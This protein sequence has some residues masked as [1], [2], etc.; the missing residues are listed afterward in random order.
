NPVHGGGADL[1]AV[2]LLVRARERIETELAGRNS[3]Q[4][5]LLCTVGASLSNLSAFAASRAA[6]EAAFKIGPPDGSGGAPVPES[7]QLDLAILLLG[8]DEIP[9]AE[10]ML[11]Q[12]EPALR[13]TGPSL[14]LAKLLST[15]SA[16]LR[17]N[18]DFEGALKAAEESAA[19]ARAAT[20][21]TSRD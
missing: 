15:R 12:I 21:A 8:T 7:C 13:A 20:S 14:E 19:V 17:T 6:Y 4:L 1:R 16:L 3:E 2:D 11:A 10:R 9:A 5:E 18:N